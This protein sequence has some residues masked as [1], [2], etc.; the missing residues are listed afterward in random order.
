MLSFSSKK[1]MNLTSWQEIDVA[2]TATRTCRRLNVTG[3]DLVNR[4]MKKIGV[5]DMCNKLRTT[6]LEED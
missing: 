2:N 6:I 5:E 4:S 3:V 1:R